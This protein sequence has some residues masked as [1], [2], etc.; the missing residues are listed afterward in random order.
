MQQR[1]QTEIR[2]KEIVMAAR[3]LIVSHG[4]ENVTVRRIADQI[5]VSEGA[6]YKHFKS[7]KAILFLLVDDMESILN[8]DIDQKITGQIGTLEKLE[9]ILIGHISGIEQRKGVTFQVIAEIVSMGDR[10]LNKK[11]SEAINKYVQR[12]EMI[13]ADGVKSGIIRPDIDLEAAARLYFGMT[14]GIVNIWALNR[15][16]FSLTSQYK[17]LWDLFLKS[18]MPASNLP[19]SSLSGLKDS[20]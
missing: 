7:K 2:Q 19:V 13:L 5:G 6:I 12:I 20:P 17:P 11:I 15:Y 1:K 10:D 3:K 16:Q 9:N 4:S 14:Q 18:V 8:A